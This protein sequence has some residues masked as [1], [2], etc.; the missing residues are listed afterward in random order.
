MPRSESIDT[1]RPVFFSTNKRDWYKAKVIARGSPGD[2]VE[3]L[4]GTT[5]KG[6]LVG[7][8]AIFHGVRYIQ[9]DPIQDKTA[10]A[11]FIP[12]E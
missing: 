10:T 5:D 7:Q 9:P 12:H 8:K 11:I 1:S 3:I 2:V 4:A 6:Y